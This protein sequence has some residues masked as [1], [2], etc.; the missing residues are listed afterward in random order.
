MP[1]SA[2]P[3]R[4]CGGGGGGGFGVILLVVVSLR[5]KGRREG[6]WPR[7]MKRLYNLDVNC[8][9]TFTSDPP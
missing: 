2:T 1:G 3:V 6:E 9:A 7:G 8:S 4:G 5:L